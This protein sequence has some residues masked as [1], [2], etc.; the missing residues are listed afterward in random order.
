MDR[1]Y[2][3]ILIEDINEFISTV[4]NEILMLKEK[5]YF[6]L[7]SNLIIIHKPIKEAI[8]GKTH[9]HKIII[10]YNPELRETSVVIYTKSF[11]KIYN[12]K[13]DNKFA[14]GYIKS[15]YNKYKEL[16][17]KLKYGW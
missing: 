15:I 6:Y 2:N 11:I 5:Y 14:F 3:Y 17:D 1:K 8:I 12:I 16:D 4:D 9:N 7:T 13:S 10:Y